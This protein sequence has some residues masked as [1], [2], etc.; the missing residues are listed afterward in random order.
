[1]L[2]RAAAAARLI[3]ALA[4]MR[5]TVCIL[6]SVLAVP[7]FGSGP[8]LPKGWRMPTDAEANGGVRKEHGIESLVHGDWDGD[9]LVDGAMLVV[10]DDGKIEGLLV[11]TF[12]RGKEKWFVLERGDFDGSLFMGLE[13]YGPGTY[14]VLCDTESECARSPTK[15]VT[16]VR[17]TIVYYRPA[18]ASLIFSWNPE[19]RIFDRI[20]ESD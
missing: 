12:P 8:T 18:S 19:R 4:A 16:F 9:G 6:L 3:V 13:K 20:W 2:F 17:D 14:E 10:S 7:A 1:M 5:A 11:V 15:S